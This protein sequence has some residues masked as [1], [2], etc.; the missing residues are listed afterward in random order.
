[1][2]DKQGR[3]ENG[4]VIMADILVV[5]DNKELGELLSDFLTA[6]GYDVYHALSGEEALELLAEE[7]AKLVILDIM[8]PGMDGFA[9]CNKIREKDN[10]PIL[11]VSAKDTKEDKLN[12]LMQGADDYIEK[13]YDIDILLAKVNGIF[14]RRY[15][16]EEIVD[17][18]LCLNKSDQSIT[19]NGQL[20]KSTAKE[21]ELLLYLLQ[22][23]NRILTKE[24]LFHQIWGNTSDSEMQTLTVHIK[25]LRNKI[26]EDPEH[27]KRIL[28]VWG[29]G[30]R[31]E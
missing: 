14:K 16:V 5:E 12:G 19:V 18:N 8:L 22:N 20:I 24:E 4:V 30:Y 10:V 27:P 1:M 6:E 23:K 9:V 11:I 3:C 17:G 29:K 28:T 13:P 26:E 7:T 31:M 15:G 21:F 25:R 2:Q